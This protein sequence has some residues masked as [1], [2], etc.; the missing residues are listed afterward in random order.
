MTLDEISEELEES[1]GDFV[2][3]YNDMN[4]T[5]TKQ[6]EGGFLEHKLLRHWDNRVMDFRIFGFRIIY[7]II[8]SDILILKLRYEDNVERKVRIM[9]N[10]CDLQKHILPGLKEIKPKIAAAIMRDCPIF[11]EHLP[12]MEYSIH[13]RDFNV[14][15][16][17]TTGYAKL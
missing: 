1:L 3:E 2:F 11:S 4:L 8:P 6:F 16:I 15:A 12:T 10:A 5:L 17:V 13:K 7:S 14:M 9:L